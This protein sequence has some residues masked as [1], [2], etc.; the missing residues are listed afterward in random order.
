MNLN[1]HAFVTEQSNVSYWPTTDNIHAF[2]TKQSNVLLA[3]DRQT[4]I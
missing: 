2:V 4:G 1:I 3:N